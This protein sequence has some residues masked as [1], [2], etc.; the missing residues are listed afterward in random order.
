MKNLMENALNSR[1][2]F[3]V[4]AVVNSKCHGM[5][6]VHVW[7][8]HPCMHT[9]FAQFNDIKKKMEACLREKLHDEVRARAQ[10]LLEQPRRYFP[11]FHMNDPKRQKVCASLVHVVLWCCVT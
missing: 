11:V 6:C 10:K 1:N 5:C 4:S 2:M 9:V 7:S 8:A 3:Q